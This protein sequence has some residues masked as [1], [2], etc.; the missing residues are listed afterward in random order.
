MEV[1][2]VETIKSN[3]EFEAAEEMKA[4]KSADDDRDDPFDSD[5]SDVSDDL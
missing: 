2:K 5:D 3:V 4:D 1:Q